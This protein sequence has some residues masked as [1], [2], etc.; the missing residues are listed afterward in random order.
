MF[1]GS[2]V[3]IVTPMYPDGAVD[4]DSL[5]ALVEWHI[6]EA[7]RRDAGRRRDLRTGRLPSVSI[8]WSSVRTRW[9][10]PYASRCANARS[11]ASSV[12]AVDRSTRSAYASVSESLGV[13]ALLTR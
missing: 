10:V 7:Q 6:S 4:W 1:S 8:A 2:I 12:P 5:A 11:R 13:R 3:A 9:I